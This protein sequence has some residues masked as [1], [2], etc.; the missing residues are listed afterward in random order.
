MGRNKKVFQPVR[1]AV[2]G[3]EG[4]RAPLVL[5]M[6]RG[7]VSVEYREERMGWLKETEKEPAHEWA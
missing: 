2:M 1:P 3:T 4:H 5:R 7:L 6:A